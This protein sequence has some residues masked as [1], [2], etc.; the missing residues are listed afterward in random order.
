M[1]NSIVK[2]KRK[3]KVKMSKTSPGVKGFCFEF[4]FPRMTKKKKRKNIKPHKSNKDI[5]TKNSYPKNTKPQRKA[6]NPKKSASSPR[7]IIFATSKQI[8]RYQRETIT[9]F[10][11][12]IWGR[13]NT[14]LSLRVKVPLS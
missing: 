9:D 11:I 13:I 7:Q 5:H 10:L 6:T 12:I 1:I 3:K 4:K 8:M 14:I 2:P